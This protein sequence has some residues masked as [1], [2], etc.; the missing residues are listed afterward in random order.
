[1][2][3]EGSTKTLLVALGGNL[4]IA[5][6]KF[7]VSFI[8]GSAAMLAESIHSAA[9][10]FNQIL[11]LIGSKRASK[12]ASELFSFGYSREIFFWSLM[13][14]ML[15]F[16]L[17]ACFS[18]YEGIDKALNPQSIH[19]IAWI[20][21]ILFSS[22]L[23]EAKSFQVAYREFRLRHKEPFFKAIKSSHNVSLV[24]VILEDS[25]ALTGLI[26]VMITTVLAWLVNPVFDAIGSIIVGCLLLAVSLLLIIEVKGLIIG[27]SIPRSDREKIKRILHS[28]PQVDHINRV[29]TMVM[30]N[31]HYL[32]LLSLDMKD[33]IK[34]YQA[35]DLVEKIKMHIMKEIEGIETIYIELR[36]A[37]RNQK[38]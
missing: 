31:N 37:V 30:G 35:E 33:E 23:I 7:T 8:T 9:D 4:L 36:D 5:G 32:V 17:G 27:E 29:Q 38:V 18:V 10:S 24:I 34:V 11:L 15:L 1:M 28:Y 6:I 19:H 16:F 26:V 12:P 20:F 14:A 3:A 25:A 21:I 22:A 13:V 2:S